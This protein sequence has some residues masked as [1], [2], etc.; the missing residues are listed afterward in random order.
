M[1]RCSVT[2]MAVPPELTAA[3][4]AGAPIY[5]GPFTG[6]GLAATFR[7]PTGRNSAEIV[8]EGYMHKV[9]G[10]CQEGQNFSNA[11][12]GALKALQM[13]DGELRFE[14]KAV[15]GR[16]RLQFQARLR[17]QDQ[18]SNSVGYVIAVQPGRGSVELRRQPAPNE[19]LRSTGD[20]TLPIGSPLM[21]GSPSRSELRARTSSSL[22]ATSRF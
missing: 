22:S 7:C 20:W 14:Y 11:G 1:Q 6:P 21:T 4:N 8:G 18:P 12:S 17:L 3:P 15:T 9:S 10:R 2:A 16:D 13:G 5:A 19:G